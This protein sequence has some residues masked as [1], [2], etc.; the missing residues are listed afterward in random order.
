MYVHPDFVTA[1]HHDRRIRYRATARRRVTPTSA[2]PTGLIAG[3][4]NPA[5]ARAARAL[6]ALSDAVE[7][8]GQLGRAE[9]SGRSSTRSNVPRIEGRAA[10]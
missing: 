5:R 6:R 10:R 2:A 4:V 9:A 7:P 3:A 1:V 8:T